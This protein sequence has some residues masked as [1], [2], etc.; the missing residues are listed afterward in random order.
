[1][2]EEIRSCVSC[3][4]SAQGSFQ[5]RCPLGLIPLVG[6]QSLCFHI[7]TATNGPASESLRRSALV[8]SD[9]ATPILVLAYY[10]VDR[11]CSSRNNGTGIVGIPNPSLE[12]FSLVCPK[13]H[14][15]FSLVGA[16]VTKRRIASFQKHRALVTSR[17]S[18]HVA[19]VSAV[20]ACPPPSPP[21]RLPSLLP[22][23]REALVLPDSMWP[24]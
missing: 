7:P 22:T 8:L 17:P 20:V 10:S 18:F 24:A 21:R 19:Q 9:E 1:M 14:R 13:S 6:V 2:Q 15:H 3:V 12:A 11:C 5:A 4:L 23:N 16:P